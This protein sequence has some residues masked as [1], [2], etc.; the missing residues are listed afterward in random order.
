MSIGRWPAASEFMKVAL[1]IAIAHSPR[2]QANA[3]P[4][5]I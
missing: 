5:A 1:V 3:G 2:A 4:D